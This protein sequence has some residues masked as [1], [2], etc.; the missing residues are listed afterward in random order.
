MRMKL[1]DKPKG[2]I[3]LYYPILWMPQWPMWAPL[4]LMVIATVLLQAGYEVVLIDERIEDDPKGWLRQEIPGA[5]FVGITAKLGGQISNA[6]EAARIV[7]SERPDCPVVFGGWFPSLF[8]NQTM[9]CPDV[10]VA[11]EGPGDFIIAEVADRIREG[12]S[13]E[14]IEGV[15]AR[16][17]DEIIK[18]PFQRLPKLDNAPSILWDE[19][20]IQRYIHPQGWLNY[21]SSRGCPGGC[22]FCAVFCLDAHRWTPLPAEQVVDEWD[23]LVN[24]LGVKAIKLLDTDFFG[25]IPRVVSIAEQL[26]ERNIKVRFEGLGRY[27]N[28]KHITDDQLRLL[29]RAG[30]TEVEIGVESGV[31][32]LCNLIRKNVEVDNFVD[33]ARRF[34]EA[35]IHVKINMMMGIP[36]ET[37]EELTRSFKFIHDFK[38]LGKGARLQYF[39]FTPLPD[40]PL[41]QEIV[42]SK[43]M[44]GGGKENGPWTLK[45]LAA[46]KINDTEGQL[47]W[48]TKKQERNVKRAYDFYGPLAYYNSIDDWSRPRKLQHLFLKMV[49][50]LARWRTLSGIYGFPFE[51][52]INQCL[53][54][55]MPRGE[56]DGLT[57]QSDVMTPKL[58]GDDFGAEPLDAPAV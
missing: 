46:L 11:V 1:V 33:L 47:Y 16:K 36:S 45:E 40:A 15:W 30:F 3:V 54:P 21:Y 39:R 8:P 25:T 4:D 27:H 24:K 52:W 44:R 5:M 13:L 7:K 20:N 14:G 57:L 34:I 28:L 9:E 26:L 43:N 42:K 55:L 17:G 6:L 29:R 41:N 12:A 48:L 2:R 58:M 23:Y 49:R 56:S 19:V 31:Q 53:G 22:T 50:P 10:D 18:S 38:A 35:G 37:N 51:M 32:R